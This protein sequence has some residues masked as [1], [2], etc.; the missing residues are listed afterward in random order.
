MEYVEGAPLNEFVEVNHPTVE[1]K[2]RLFLKICRAVSHAHQNLVVHRDLKPSNI[3]ITKGGEPKLLDFGLAKIAAPAGEDFDAATAPEQTKTFFRAFTPAYASPEQVHGGAVTTASDVYSLGV[4]LYELLTGA[5]PFQF[6]SK[7]LDEILKTVDDADEPVRPSA[8]RDSE[9]KTRNSGLEA[10][11]KPPSDIHNPR[12]LRGDLDNITLKALRKEPLRRYRSVE[13]FADDIERHL[14]NLPIEARPNTI[15]Y[16]AAR[17]FRRNRVAVS[18]GAFIILAL[19]SGLGSALWQARIARIERDRAENRFADVRQLSNSLLFELSP[20]LERL[21]GSIEAREI[22]VSRALEYLDSLAAEAQ[23]DDRL[24]AE[25]AA[26]YE[27]I[28]DLQGNPTNPNLIEFEAAIISY[29]KANA[30]RRNLFEKNPTDAETERRLAENY[31][32]LGN[33]Y[34]QVNEI[35]ASARNTKQSLEIYERLAAANPA[36]TDLRFGLAKV[37]YDFGLNSQT[38]KN[39][40]ESLVF[41]GKAKTLLVALD[42]EKP[43][44]TEIRRTLAETEIQNANALSWS[45]RQPEAEREAAEART[46]AEELFAENPN[47]VAVRGSIWLIYWLTCNIYQDQNDDLADD[48]ARRALKIVEGTVA[49]DAANLRAKQ[50]LAKSL[51]TLGQTATTVGKSEAAVSYLEKSCRLLGEITDATTK[52]NRL[53]SEL[54]LSLMRLGSAQIEQGTLEKALE[55]LQRAAATYREIL[56]LAP[57]DRRSNRNLAET[58]EHL[59]AVYAKSYG[60]TKRREQRDAAQANYQKSLDILTRLDAG[61][62]LAEA[63]RKLLQEMKIAVENIKKN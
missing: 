59:G 60:R 26:A 16:R 2:L 19:L 5:K 55:N 29:E 6:E 32:V 11:E 40:S 24:Q 30:R 34:S 33:I 58:Y 43:H 18:A 37:Y 42:A 63:D 48:Y 27:K 49:A 46:I 21:P 53:R 47:D 10:G 36:A 17:F 61:R 41:F 7:N 39:Y 56:Q 54:A 45:E 35:G 12:S 44:Q 31:R 14:K 50:Q 13:A 51:S 15:S 8:V 22:L 9:P 4:V 38:S 1:E 62:A 28:G 57:E 3:L 20:K 23:N 25:L 52:N